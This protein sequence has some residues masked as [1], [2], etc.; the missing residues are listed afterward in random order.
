MGLVGLTIASGIAA[1]IEFTLLRNSMNHKI[2]RTGLHTPDMAKLWG[3]AIGAAAVAFAVKL[4]TTGLPP[5]VSGAIVLSAFGAVYIGATAA[6]GV[7]ESR[8]LVQLVRN[9]LNI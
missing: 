7:S 4:K 3:I 1:W 6:F 9:R 2:G 5:L 8:K